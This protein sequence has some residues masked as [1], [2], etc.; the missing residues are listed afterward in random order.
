MN[1]NCVAA[2]HIRGLF[3]IL[4]P[5]RKAFLL[6]AVEDGAIGAVVEGFTN[7]LSQ[8]PTQTTS[9]TSPATMNTAGITG[10]AAI[11]PIMVL[12]TIKAIVNLKILERNLDHLSTRTDHPNEAST[13]E[14]T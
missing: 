12:L 14:V 6:T 11:M 13:T 1:I 3:P 5:C 7:L 10:T 2:R 4:S 9:K 8:T